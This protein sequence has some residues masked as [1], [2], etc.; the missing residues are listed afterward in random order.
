[1]RPI[2]PLVAVATLALVTGGT[3]AVVNAAGD[4]TRATCT[5]APLVK[6]V[7][8]GQRIQVV[9]TVPAPPPATVT[10]TASPSQPPTS[11]P[12]EP[13]ETP[14]TQEPTP[15]DPPYTPP[16]GFPN[17]TNTGVP[18]GTVLTDYTGP[19]LITEPNAVIDAKRITGDLRIRAAGVTVRNSKIFGDVR[20]DADTV[21]ASF[22]ITDSEVD[23]GSPLGENAYDGTA[24]GA[25]DFTAIRV[26]V[27]NGK[28]GIN[29][30]LNCT[31]RDSFIEGPADDP[32]GQAHESGMRMGAGS[33]I[34]GNTLRCAAKDYPPDAGCSAA[35]TGYGDFATVENNLIQGNLFV[36]GSGGFCAYGGSSAGKPFPNSNNIRFLDNVFQRGVSGKCGFWGPIADF[37]P[38][39][40]GNRWERNT[41]DDGMPVSP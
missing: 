10:V 9:C 13:T 19:M 24:I 6:Q 22:T 29:C 38:S 31:V 2:K 15:S 25:R 33:T 39:A 37:N 20:I 11:E 7:E 21:G 34:V 28:R 35:L 23:A 30:F 27:Y 32:T 12:T 3:V 1:M 5:R 8:G 16:A 14:T 4:D 18:A 40:P 41:W 17:A 36:A 26:H